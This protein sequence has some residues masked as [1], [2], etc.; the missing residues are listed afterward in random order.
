MSDQL[1]SKDVDLPTLMAW[2]RDRHVQE[3]AAGNE[4]SY[5]GLIHAHIE[6]LQREL[7]RE[8]GTREARVA[9]IDALRRQLAK[10]PHEREGPHCSTCACGMEPEQL[11]GPCPNCNQWVVLK[12]TAKPPGDGQ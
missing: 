9:E 5:E 1:P 3:A 4:W 8:V 7:A 2:L 11:E 12:A 10:P 6:H